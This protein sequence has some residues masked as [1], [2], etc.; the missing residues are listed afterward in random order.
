MRGAKYS[1]SDLLFLKKKRK[2]GGIKVTDVLF[3]AA[4]SECELKTD[5]I[6][7]CNI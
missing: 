2:E 4:R 7:I 1:L 6:N 5:C 3:H